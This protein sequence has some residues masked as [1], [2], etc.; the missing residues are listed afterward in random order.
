MPTFSLLFHIGTK[1]LVREIRQEKEI[2]RIQIGKKEIKLS[3]LT[4]SMN[5]YTENILKNKQT[6]Y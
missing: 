4:D 2:K 6:N 3:L 5:L 1:V